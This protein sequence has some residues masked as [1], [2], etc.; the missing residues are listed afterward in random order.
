MKIT[1]I[2][3]GNM[4]GAMAR[5]MAAGK[6]VPASNIYVTTKSEASAQKISDCDPRI[7]TG[8]DNRKAVEGAD[9]IILAIKPWL[10]EG[11]IEEIKSGLDYTRQSIASVVAGV[12]FESLQRMLDNGSGVR[13]TLFRIIP[14][15]AISIGESVTFIAAEGADEQQ[16]DT[17]KRIF[18][19]LG[20]TLVIPE[21]MMPAGTSLASCGI[22]FALRYMRDSMQGGVELGFTP[23][24]ARQIVMQTVRG[25]LEMLAHN[26]TMPQTEIDKVTTPGGITLKGLSAMDEAGFTAAVKA[27][28]IKSR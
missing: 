3:G 10:L 11:V 23:Q 7:H 15:T 27:G 4:G 6:I 17:L 9:L 20:L 1:I 18:D 8:T 5:G 13:P 16:I 26:D 2:G 14:N 21:A 12:N 25:A 24:E 22:A 28:L 19:E